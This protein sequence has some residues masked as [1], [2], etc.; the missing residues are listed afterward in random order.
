MYEKLQFLR[1]KLKEL[2]Y[3]PDY[4]SALHDVEDEQK[5][6]MLWCHS[7]RLAIG[8]ALINTAEGITITVMKNLRVCEDCH[9]V[10]KLISRVVGREIFLR[11][12]T[13]FHHFKD[14]TCSC[15]DY[16]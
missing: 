11:D 6:E 2:G 9:T 4:R 12:S 14:G 1:D 16:W 3:T 15:G 5:E 13:R 8:F 10:I 7:E